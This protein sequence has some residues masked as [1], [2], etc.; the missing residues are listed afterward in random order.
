MAYTLA[1]QIQAS[2]GN[3]LAKSESQR[4]ETAS[5]QSTTKFHFETAQDRGVYTTP[6]IN[7]AIAYSLPH[8]LQTNQLVKLLLLVPWPFLISCFKA[9]VINISF[10]FSSHECHTSFLIDRPI[11][12]HDATNMNPTAKHKTKQG[13]FST[14][15]AIHAS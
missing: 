5:D 12:I 9:D 1:L 15:K 13:T 8:W 6:D 7:K 10:W 4:G 2:G 11:H 3:F 14:S